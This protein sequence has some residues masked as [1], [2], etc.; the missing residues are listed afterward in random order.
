M[1]L[2]ELERGAREVYSDAM[3]VRVRFHKDVTLEH[4]DTIVDYKGW[5]QF[6]TINH[7]E[8]VEE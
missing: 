4:T 7:H 6:A 3:E 2:D 5:H 8:D 1:L